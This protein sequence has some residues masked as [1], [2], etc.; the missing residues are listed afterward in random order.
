MSPR[1]QPGQIWSRSCSLQGL[2]LV[3]P[4]WGP[5][6]RRMLQAARTAQY[7]AFGRWLLCGC[8]AVQKC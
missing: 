1:Q 4:R 7:I 6:R 8:E 2:L 5:Y 3:E